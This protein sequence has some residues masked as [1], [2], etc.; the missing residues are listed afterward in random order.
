MVRRRAYLEVGGFDELIFFAGEETLLAVDL[1]RA[2]WESVYVDSVVAH[3]HPARRGDGSGRRR[4]Q[5]RNGLLTTWMCRPV[6]VAIRSTLA[7]AATA[8]HDV[9]ARGGLLDGGNG[10]FGADA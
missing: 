3:H 2:G 10:A 8:R 5:S 4:L 6:G 1:A 9:D 7:M